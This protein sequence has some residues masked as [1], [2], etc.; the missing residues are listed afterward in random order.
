LFGRERPKRETEERL[1]V[2]AKAKA[3]AKAAELRESK[4]ICKK[5]KNH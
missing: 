1:R 2:K 5:R 4:F 3:K